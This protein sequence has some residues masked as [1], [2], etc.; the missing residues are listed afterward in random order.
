MDIYEEY[1]EFRKSI[2][3]KHNIKAIADENFIRLFIADKLN[4]I[5]NQNKK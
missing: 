1:E 5:I 4:Q 3:E 2:K